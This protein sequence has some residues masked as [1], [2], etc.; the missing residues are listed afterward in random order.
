M[1]KIERLQSPEILTE[2]FAE[3]T[4]AFV[5]NPNQKVYDCRTKLYKRIK[6]SL[7][8]MTQ[9]HCTF[10]DG[11]PIANTGDAIEHFRPSSV[12]HDLSYVW[13]NL[14]YICPKCNSAKGNRF[15]ERLLKPDDIGYL[16]DNYFDYNARDA[17][18]EAAKDISVED[19]EKA[20]KTIELYELNRNW[21]KIERRRLIKI[22]VR[23][24]HERD[25]FPYR[26]IIDLGL[27]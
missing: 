16:F 3:K 9:A 15:D 10:C 26:Y 25:D 12:H 14:Y 7:M 8:L 17:K 1:I 18:L 6:E 13:E 21:N 24:T 19:I 11:F 20:E 5:A 23:G 2:N 22:F 27:I 4:L